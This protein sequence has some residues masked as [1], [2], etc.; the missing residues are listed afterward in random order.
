V[1]RRI[2]AALEINLTAADEE[3]FDQVETTVTGAY[4][5]VLRGVERYNVFNSEAVADARKLF[6]QA[7]A[8]DPDYARAYANIALTYATEVNFFW[9]RNREESIRLGLEFASKALDLDDTIPQIYLTRS[10]LYLSQR[11]HQAALEAAQRTIEVHPNY[12]DGYATLAF[13]SSYAGEFE[14]AL[15]ALARA[16]QINPQGTGV[17]LA[18][19]GRIR[20]LAKRYDE[21]LPLLE[22]SVD[23]NPGFDRSHLNLAAIYAELGRIDDAA[24]SVEEA[25]AI[26]PDITLERERRNTLYMRDAD[27]EHYL[28]ALRK[29]GLPE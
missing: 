5:L 1:N 26:S 18:V 23:R 12:A 9:S 27:I 16:S 17:Y 19:E 22:E 28:G 11:Q 14:Q 15:D 13:I 2:V 3:R 10:I 8:L 20:F 25:L 29:A 7:A 4:D 6:K 24:W 21:A